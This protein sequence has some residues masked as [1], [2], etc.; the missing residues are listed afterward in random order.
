MT[1]LWTWVKNEGLKRKASSVGKLFCL[2]LPACFSGGCIEDFSPTVEDFESSLVVEAN[3]TDG[4]GPYEI[5]LSRSRQITGAV[6]RPEQGASVCVTTTE[7]ECYEFKE[8]APGKYVSDSCTWRGKVGAVYTLDVVTGGKHY[9]SFPDT[10]KYTPPIDSIY[11]EAENRLNRFGQ[12]LSGIAVMVDSHD[13][14]GKTKYYKYDWV[15]SWEIKVEW[16]VVFKLWRCYDSDTTKTILLTTT[17]QLTE[18]RVSRFELNYVSTQGF[19]LVSM[20]SMLVKQTALD[21]NAFKYWS[22]IKKLNESTG[23]LY[24]PQPYQVKSN[25][26][27]TDDA[28]EQVLCYFDASS[29]QEKRF[30]V[31]FDQLRGL[32]WPGKSCYILAE[33][34]PEHLPRYCTDCTYHGGS[35]IKPDFWP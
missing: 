34:D 25:I 31:F 15:E 24:D 2:L 14:T 16:P 1:K 23:T 17:S 26:F 9:Q 18:D 20:Y 4:K 21:E 27:N 32:D 28:S 6:D 11:F 10:V 19:R 33:L 8:I 5:K 13:K 30:F 29:I 12:P 3:I 35:L 7:G 22:E